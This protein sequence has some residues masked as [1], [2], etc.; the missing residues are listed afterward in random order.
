[1]QIGT[2]LRT[3]LSRFLLFLLSVVYAPFILIALMLPKAWVLDSRFY[4]RLAQF[5]YWA[6]IKISFLSITIEGVE[7]IPQEPVIFVANHQSSFD[8]PLLG[9]LV[10]AHPHVWFALKELLKSPVLRFLVPQFSVLVDMSSPM[11]GMRSLLQIIKLLTDRPHHCM[12]FP[13]GGRFT[14]GVVHDFYP[15]F[16]ILAK[17][18]GRPVVPVYIHNVNKAYPPDV[19][20]I[21][22]YPI[23]VV[24]G[25][26]FI[27]QEGETEQEFKDRV[28]AWF[29]EQVDRA[30]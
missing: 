21:H 12:V 29:G 18:L 27:M 7:N 9:S 13:E 26:P 22:N 24:I 14:D 23:K 30:G 15:G 8:V 10:G 2:L 17:K 1:M 25:K 5:F 16:A 4:F 28:Y 11:S 20:L 19:F 6:A 3:L